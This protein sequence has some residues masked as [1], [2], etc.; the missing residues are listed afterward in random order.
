MFSGVLGRFAG[1]LGLGYLVLAEAGL[2]GA[3]VDQGIGESGH[4]ARGLPHFGCHEYGGVE[5]LDVVARLNH[6]PPPALLDVVLELHAEGAVVPDRSQPTVD[7]RG[8]KDET[9]ALA[10]GDQ[11]VHHGGVGHA[12]PGGEN[13]GSD[14]PEDTR[15]TPW[16]ATVKGPVP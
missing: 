7:L 1:T 10:Q 4:V 11:L 12:E 8:L 16:G 3:A 13:R 2:A 15:G 5:A 9:A 6:G 14:G